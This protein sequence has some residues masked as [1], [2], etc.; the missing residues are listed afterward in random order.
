MNK[1]KNRKFLALSSS[2]KRRRLH[3]VR[4]L[5]SNVGTSA[6]NFNGSDSTSADESFY[7]EANQMQDF[8]ADLSEIESEEYENE[9]QLSDDDDE[10]VSSYH[11]SSDE[12]A[13]D[14]L[15]VE[16]AEENVEGGDIFEDDDE[17]IPPFKFD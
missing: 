17:D 2:Q 3:T 1:E 11:E 8:P 4:N 13:F 7:N 15:P 12:E 16:R 6:Q 5:T 10:T 9:S 14:A